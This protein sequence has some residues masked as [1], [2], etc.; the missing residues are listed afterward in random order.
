MNQLAP[1]STIIG[2]CLVTAFQVASAA[3]LCVNPGGSAGCKA[4]INAAVAATSAGDTIR[5]AA[6][7]YKEDVV[8]T[9]S[10]SLVGAGYTQ[11]I[12]EA[13]GKS[14]GIF[15]DGIVAA[16]AAGVNNGYHLR[17][18]HTRCQL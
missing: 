11:T 18:H 5:V 4:S 10:L 16:P 14:N 7:V 8:I 13:H 9:K 12:I 17:L 15:I 2:I 3:T 6:G 1:H